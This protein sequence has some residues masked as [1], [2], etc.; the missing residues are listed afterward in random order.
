MQSQFAFSILTVQTILYGWLVGVIAYFKHFSFYKYVF[1]FKSTGA[2]VAVYL[3]LV[4]FFYYFC[5]FF[6]LK[7]TNTLTLVLN[8]LNYKI[9][10]LNYYRNFDRI[11]LSIK[12]IWINYKNYWIQ[13]RIGQRFVGIGKIYDIVAVSVKHQF[14]FSLKLVNLI[15]ANAPFLVFFKFYILFVY[16]FITNILFKCINLRGVLYFTTS[17]VISLVVDFLKK[18]IKI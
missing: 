15:T 3:V 4:Q 10:K 18:L 11:C 8:I 12:K 14:E 16:F 13:D 1:I 5:L 9:F 2:C 17:V 6:L 7:K